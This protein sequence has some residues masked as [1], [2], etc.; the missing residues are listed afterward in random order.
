MPDT[1]NSKTNLTTA[2]IIAAGILLFALGHAL[3]ILRFFIF[4]FVFIA[5]TV[6]YIYRQK[7][8]IKNKRFIL[9]VFIFALSIRMFFSLGAHFY[10]L[11][12]NLNGFNYAYIYAKANDEITYDRTG[13][14]IVDA[15]N[16]NPLFFLNKDESLPIIVK[17]VH[18]GY[19]LFIAALYYLCGSGMLYAKLINSL[20][21]ALIVV[22]VYLIGLYFFGKNPAKLAA[23]LVAADSYAVLYS[24]YL[25]KE[26]FLAFLTT[27]AIWNYLLYL[28]EGRKISLFWCILSALISLITRLYLG[29]AIFFA[30]FAYILIFHVPKDPV[31]KFLYVFLI[32]AVASPLIYVGGQFAY[33]TIAGGGF[34]SRALRSVASAKGGSDESANLREAF[35]V[36][37]LALNTLRMF[38]SPMPWR[39][40]DGS[41]EIMFYWGY[42]GRW[43]WYV[44][45]PFF[46]YGLYYLLRHYFRFIFVPALSCAAYL[47][48]CS[49]VMMSGERHHIAVMPFLFLTAAVGFCTIRN[50]VLPMLFYMPFLCAFYCYDMQKTEQFVFSFCLL[51]LIYLYYVI[52]KFKNEIGAES[53]LSFLKADNIL[54]N[55]VTENA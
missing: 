16:N 49:L 20:L 19:N 11:R 48:I 1:K 3:G 44:F 33:T 38:L 7:T 8:D 47:F 32:L 29:A 40:L 41:K 9:T 2:C 46:F 31:K 28:K 24:S 53:F 27:S 5:G 21:G 18:V 39:N 17:N 14:L 50:P 13:K 43:L 42:P 15:F 35:S 10:S 23:I 36:K 30:L 55:E 22:Y 25:Y 34:R 6:Y 52:R 4:T 12:H 51:G 26:I 54:E 45:M 37:R